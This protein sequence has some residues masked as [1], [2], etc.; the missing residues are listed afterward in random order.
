MHC[1]CLCR[2][3]R[4]PWPHEHGEPHEVRASVHGR[5]HG[6]VRERDAVAP[7]HMQR[8]HHHAERRGGRR[9]EHGERPWWHVHV[10]RRCR[11]PGRRQL[12]QLWLAGLRRRDV[13]DVQPPV[14]SFFAQEGDVCRLLWACQPR[15]RLLVCLDGQLHPLELRCRVWRQRARRDRVSEPDQVRKQLSAGRV[16]ERDA[17]TQPH[18]QQR[19]LRSSPKGY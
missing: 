7:A 9:A 1:L 10:P 5:L 12:R 4:R 16:R 19:L 14:W 11:V 17:D 2:P 18:V 15:L 3:P 13:G 6:P 8:Q